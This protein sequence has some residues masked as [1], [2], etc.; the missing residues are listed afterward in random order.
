MSSG[1]SAAEDGPAS[2]AGATA[3][4]TT[5]PQAAGDAGQF[6]LSLLA[7]PFLFQVSGA[8]ARIGA[9]DALLDGP[10]SATAVAEETEADPSAM[11][12]LLRAG[13]ALGLVTNDADGRFELTA[14]GVEFRARA[15][16]RLTADLYGTP[17][18]WAAFGALEEAVR[19]GTP[20]FVLEHGSDV[21]QHFDREPVLAERFNAAMAMATATQTPAIVDGYPFGKFQHLVDVGGGDGTLLAAVLAA[22]PR[23]RGTLSERAEALGAAAERLRATGTEERCALVEGDFMAGVPEG[24]DGYLLRNILHG[25]DD[26]SCVRLLRNCRAAGGPD[27]TVVVAT[28]LVPPT[29]G[30]EPPTELPAGSG[31]ESAAG[32]GTPGAPLDMSLALSDIETLLLTSGRERTADEYRALLLRAGLRTTSVVPVPELPHYALLEAVP[33]EGSEPSETAEPAGPSTG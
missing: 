30:T 7:A 28:L 10:L 2:P 24:G 29:A 33:T 25:M 31:T 21:Y 8:L 4:E 19:T 23:L 22:N 12:R 18:V 5:T 15:P 16:F 26:E 20:A 3:S 14:L 17:S 32:A 13:T 6:Q 9:V 27:C 11:H 1:E